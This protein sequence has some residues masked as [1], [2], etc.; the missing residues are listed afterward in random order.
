MEL[1]LYEGKLF[2]EINIEILLTREAKHMIKEF[3]I[4]F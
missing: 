1:Q 2:H 4:N 3:L